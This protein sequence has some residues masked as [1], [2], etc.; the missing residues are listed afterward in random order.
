MLFTPNYAVV[1]FSF[2]SFPYIASV[3][4]Q[5]SFGF[6]SFWLRHLP[7]LFV[8]RGAN[9]RSLRVAFRSR[10]QRCWGGA[11][12]LPQG[13]P[14]LMLRYETNLKIGDK[15]ALREQ[16]TEIFS[17]FKVD[18]ENGQFRS[19]VVSAHEKPTGFISRSRTATTSF[20]RSEL[21]ASAVGLETIM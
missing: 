2:P 10:Y 12:Q 1:Y 5:P 8:Y 9:H 18:A 11:Y 6:S 19:A 20:T 16:V 4:N 21:T 17:V 13:P 14:A 7:L 3:R 15:T